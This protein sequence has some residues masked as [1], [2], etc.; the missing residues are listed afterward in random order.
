[1]HW[2]RKVAAASS[3]QQAALQMVLKSVVN[4]DSQFGEA[5]QRNSKIF[6]VQK[7]RNSSGSPAKVPD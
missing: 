6:T 7:K 3:K 2:R 1:M 5:S 4:G